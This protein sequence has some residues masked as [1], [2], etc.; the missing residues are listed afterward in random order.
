MPI[1]PIRSVTN[2]R[3]DDC[4]IVT[5]K[6]I[7]ELMGDIAGVVDVSA[8]C[9]LIGLLE[10]RTQSGRGPFHAR[11]RRRQIGEQIARET[12]GSRALSAVI[13]AAGDD[14]HAFDRGR[15]RDPELHGHEGAGGYAGDR[16]FLYVRIVGAQ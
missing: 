3:V 5:G 7:Y 16:T 13:R 4:I 12:L 6:N 10:E 15:P 14:A 1:E 9:P 2:F 11:T 8:S